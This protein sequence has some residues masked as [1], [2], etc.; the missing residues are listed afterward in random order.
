MSCCARL[1]ACSTQLLKELSTG[2]PP[3]NPFKGVPLTLSCK[4]QGLWA[5]GV[6]LRRGGSYGVGT[7]Q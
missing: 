7:P 5:A 4:E 6:R 1:G 2:G 3:R